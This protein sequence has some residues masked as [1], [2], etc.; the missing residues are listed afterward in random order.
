MTNDFLTR[1]LQESLLIGD[2]AMG[3]ML[4]SK[5]VFLN[6]CF[7]ELSLTRPELIRKIHAEYIAAGC[8]FIETNSFGANEMKLSQFGLADSVEALNK[9]AAALARDEERSAALAGR[10]RSFAERHLDSAPAVSRLRR[11]LG[12]E[13][14]PALVDL[15]LDELGTP[16]GSRLRRRAD[17][18]LHLFTLEMTP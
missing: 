7:D 12:L 6:T 4:Y 17:E 15:R 13:A 16:P 8:D 2:G 9:A 3:T 10:A 11:A 1:R 14:E 5:G 18:A